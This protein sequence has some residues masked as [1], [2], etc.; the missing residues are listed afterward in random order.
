MDVPVVA[1]VFT[2]I[3]VVVVVV[4]KQRGRTWQESLQSIGWQNTRLNWYG[5]GLIL[6]AAGIGIGWLAIQMLPREILESPNINLS[7]YS[8]IPFGPGLILTVVLKEAISAFG[9]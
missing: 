1:I 2:I 9:E 4:Q 3:A 6:G 5:V 8:G 7:N